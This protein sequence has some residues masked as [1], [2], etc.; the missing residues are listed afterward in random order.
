MLF[1]R[2]QCARKKAHR[3]APA[4]AAVV[5]RLFGLKPYFCVS[6]AV[7]FLFELARIV[8]DLHLRFRIGCMALRIALEVGVRLQEVIIVELELAAVEA[9]LGRPAVKML[10][11]GPHLVSREERNVG[12][13]GDGMMRGFAVGKNERMLVFCM[14][15]K[16]VDSMLLH[17]PA[18]EGKICF[19][20]LDAI[21]KLGKFAGRRD[22]IVRKTA[23]GEN[24]L[25]D[26][27]R[28]FVFEIRQSLVR[29]SSQSQGRKVNS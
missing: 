1:E 17:K 2:D 13:T 21:F 16:I 22:P 14:F 23:I 26:V 28:S 27:D 5:R 6:L 18:D 3:L 24:F 12:K 15:E 7:V 4:V 20:I 10:L 9:A 8:V 25:D 11:V 29:D 19:T